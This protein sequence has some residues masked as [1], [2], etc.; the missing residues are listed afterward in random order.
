MPGATSP[1]KASE[2]WKASTSTVPTPPDDAEKSDKL[3]H[4]LSP[5]PAR[6]SNAMSEEEIATDEI[7]QVEPKV[8]HLYGI[9]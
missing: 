7:E 4:N 6:S 3:D 2:A 8:S 9:Y 5:S 1:R